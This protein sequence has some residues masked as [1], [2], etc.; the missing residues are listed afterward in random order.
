MHRQ[1]IE[2]FARRYKDIG[3]RRLI[4]AISHR[5]PTINRRP[6]T[7]K[8]EQDSLPSEGVKVRCLRAHGSCFVPSVYAWQPSLLRRQAVWPR[9]LSCSVGREQ[10]IV[11]SSRSR[12][13]RQGERTAGKKSEFALALHTKRECSGD[14][15]EVKPRYQEHTPPIR[16]DGCSG[17]TG[18]NTSRN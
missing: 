15:P 14:L 18:I 10:R 17:Q 12:G 2:R 1:A 13:R 8:T 3:E 5:H 4:E 11:R 6:Q 16:G 9:G 7:D